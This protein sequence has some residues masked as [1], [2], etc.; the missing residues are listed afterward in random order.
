MRIESM[1]RENVC[2]QWA[3]E[4][5]VSKSIILIETQQEPAKPVA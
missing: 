1:A 3:L 4:R 5:R 2:S